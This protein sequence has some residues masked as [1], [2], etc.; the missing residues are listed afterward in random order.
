MSLGHYSTMTLTRPYMSNRVLS[1]P[2]PRITR[3]TL[4]CSSSLP[5][6]YPIWTIFGIV[7]TLL[8][9]FFE[10]M[11]PWAVIAVITAQASSGVV[12]AV[13]FGLTNRHATEAILRS[14]ARCCQCER[15][16]KTPPWRAVGGRDGRD[17][18]EG[19]KGRDGR[20]FDNVVSAKSSGGGGSSFSYSSYSGADEGEG[21]ERGERDGRGGSGGGGGG[22]SSHFDGL[23]SEDGQ[24][25]Y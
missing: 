19:R 16:R 11:P 14:L 18:R 1:P 3:Q 7:L 24:H 6:R 10:G 23:S 5:S 8:P 15:R 22:S 25:I 17:G 9:R 20:D 21:S 4:R 2:P 12:D 13:L